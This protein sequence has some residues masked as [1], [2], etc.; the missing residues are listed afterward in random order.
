M[1]KYCGFHSIKIH[2]YCVK[3]VQ[4]RSFFWSVFSRY[5]AQIRENTNRKNSEFG[6]FSPSVMMEQSGK[7]LFKIYFK[8]LVSIYKF[9]TLSPTFWSM[10]IKSVNNWGLN[11]QI[12]TFCFS[13]RFFS[14]DSFSHFRKVASSV[15]WIW[16]PRNFANRTTS[17][18]ESILMKK[19]SRL[20]LYEKGSGKIVFLWILRNL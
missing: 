18:L 10:R 14:L 9:T 13:F 8:Y 7:S 15:L 4:I 17:V 11:A 12:L 5:S 6:Y 2:W 3:R 1:Q 20:Q 19:V 16:V